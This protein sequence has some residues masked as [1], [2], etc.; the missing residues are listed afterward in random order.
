MGKSLSNPKIYQEIYQ[1]IAL[2]HPKSPAKWG[3]MNAAQ[4]LWHCHKILEIPTGNL[5]LQE[6]PIV[7]KAIGIFTKYEIQ[8][9][10]NGIPHNMPTFG[11]VKAPKDCNFEESESALLKTLADYQKLS[12]QN[13]L[14]TKHVL[15][16]KMKKSDWDFLEYKHLDHHLKQ[17]GV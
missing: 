12:I 9:L 1:R 14:P 15:F 3:K 11:V 13:K 2:L 7:F 5:F 10:N 16:G 17:F 6:I 4:M 8:W